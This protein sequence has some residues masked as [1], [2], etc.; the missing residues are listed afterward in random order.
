[1]G[2]GMIASLPLRAAWR[3]LKTMRWRFLA[4]AIILGSGFGMFT[5]VYSAIDSL[6]GFRDQLY[7]QSNIAGFELRFSPEDQINL[8]SWSDIGGVNQAE[9]RL[10]LPGNIEL[11]E[12]RRLSALL[13]GLPEQHA[14]NKLLLTQ[15]QDIDHSLPNEIV[16]DRN[17]ARHY[18][19]K[20]GDSIWLNVGKDRM[21]LKIRGVATSTEHLVD[22]ANPNFF[23]PAK[24][25]LGV[26]F[27]PLKLMDDRLGFRLVNSVLFTGHQVAQDLPNAAIQEILSKGE[28]KLTLEE[29][30]PLS[31]QFGHMF[32]NLDLNAFKIFTPAIV[33]I[34]TASAITILFFLLHQWV[35]QQRQQL[36]L[37]ASL[38]YKKRPIISRILGPLLLIALGGL[39]AGVAFSY[40]LL[41]GFG[42]EY[43][44]AVGLPA[45]SLD[46]VPAYL[47]SASLALAIVCLLGAAIPLRQALKVTP[48]AAVRGHAQTPPQ[49]HGQM[50]NAIQ[51]ASWRYA[52]RAILRHRK[53]SLMTLVAVALA[54]APALAYFVALRSFENAIVD[55]FDKDKWSYSIDFMSPVWD[56]ELASI[57]SIKGITAVDP[58]V[59]GVVRYEANGIQESGLITGIEP[60]GSLRMPEI[61]EGRILADTDQNAIIMERKLARS[62]RL[63]VG[64]DVTVDGRLGKSSAKLVGIFSGA[65]PGESFTS[66]ED[67]RHWLDLT[68]QNTGVLVASE[69]KA[70]LSMEL[71]KDRRVAKVTVR[72]ALVGEVIKHL[73]EIA[74]IV[75]LAAA[76]S[77]IVALLFLFTSS[78]FAFMAREAD[79]ALLQ[80]L[81]FERS[82]VGVMVRKEVWL[83]GGIGVALALPL[84]F[85]LAAWL[86]GILGEAWFN[87]PT[88][89]DIKDP[90]SI[91]IPALLLLPLVARPVIKRINA[92]NLVDVL[93]RRSFG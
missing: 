29:S 34:F 65:L 76:F 42:H 81:G 16:I 82:S 68:E 86:N 9:A 28:R 27:A 32:L 11:N 53:A 61:L 15:G 10:L 54:L 55:S 73:K 26:I 79:F 24:G 25:S 22:G 23:L 14:I 51:N 30:V 35:A 40:L 5:G 70:D 39:V 52:V 36:G 67:A 90:A 77:I 87:I 49:G 2:A 45:P 38:G 47:V 12:G 62:L 21:Q 64:D 7:Q 92:I 48:L 91:A 1:M 8:P 74:G 72:E 80:I 60:K 31:R 84:G 75:Y 17:L 63:K 13:V 89:F 85:A 19:Y 33:I 69:A 58:F 46:L 78:S 43:A 66:R 71:Y 6:F 4:V 56:D 83:L 57:K 3:D 41:Y 20:T 44:T 18:G 59:R 88:S 50:A 93:R 37:F